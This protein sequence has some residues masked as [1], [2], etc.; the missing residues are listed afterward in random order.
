M[1]QIVCSSAV[2]PC[3]LKMEWDRP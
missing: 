2:M 1:R 3:Q